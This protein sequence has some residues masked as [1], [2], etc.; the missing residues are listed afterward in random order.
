LI[1]AGV[2]ADEAEVRTALKAKEAEAPRDDWPGLKAL[3]LAQSSWLRPSHR[4]FPDAD[5]RC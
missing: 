4:K 2:D 5:A 3:F 1:S